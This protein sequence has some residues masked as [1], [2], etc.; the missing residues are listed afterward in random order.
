M[1]QRTNNA[2]A[3]MV[4]TIK[5]LRERRF[6]SPFKSEYMCSCIMCVYL[7]QKSDGWDADATGD[8]GTEE[9]WESLDGD[10]GQYSL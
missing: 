4:R 2:A 1:S 3:T 10:Q 6:E 8:W 5:V 7:S 9:N